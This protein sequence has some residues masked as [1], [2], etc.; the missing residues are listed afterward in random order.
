MRSQPDLPPRLQLRGVTKVYGRVTVLDAV[1]LEVAPGETLL[2]AGSNGSGKSTLLRC[3]AGLARYGGEVR[4][5]GRPSRRTPANR[6]ALG[7]LPQ[8]PGLPAWATGA[9]VLHLF[10]RLRG[11]SRPAVELPADFLPPLDRPVGQLSGGQRQR[12]AIVV[13][14]LG[15]PRLLLLDEPAAN[16]DEEGREALA[17]LVGA[18]RREGTSVVVAAPSPGELGDLADRT[19]RLVDG[20]VAAGPHLRP[21]PPGEAPPRLTAIR[22]A[23]G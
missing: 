1:D 6:E 20:K 4:F 15:A 5:D 7:Y 14:L 11:A 22:G 23:L 3:V 19:V 13:A 10:G 8:A 2:L 12:I 21:A 16:L 9:E 18:V 17:Q